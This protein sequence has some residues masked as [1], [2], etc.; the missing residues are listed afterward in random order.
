[1]SINRSN[2]NAS[3]EFLFILGGISQ[4]S[5]AATAVGLFENIRPGG[6]AL[7][8]VLAAA[9]AIIFFRRSW[10]RKWNKKDLLWASAFGIV[11]AAMNLSIYLAI[12]LLPLGNAVAIEFLGPIAVAAIG[13]RTIK[14]VSSLGIASVGVIIHARWS[15]RHSSIRNLRNEYRF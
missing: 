9:L 3:P 15:V 10:K 6:V 5:G 11:L 14:S 1:M 4:Y 8:R 12:E 7:L 2:N 13:A